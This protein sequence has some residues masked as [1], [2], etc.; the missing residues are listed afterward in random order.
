VARDAGRRLGRRVIGVRV[1]P[2]LAQNG[3]VH[4]H[5]GHRDQGGG[6]DSRRRTAFTTRWQPACPDTGAGAGAGAGAEAGAGDGYAPANGGKQS[7]SPWGNSPRNDAEPSP[8]PCA[9][10]LPPPFR[11]RRPKPSWTSGPRP[12]RVGGPCR[13]QLAANAVCGSAAPR[14]LRVSSLGPQQWVS[15]AVG[16][17]PTAVVG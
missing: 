7:K 4:T 3:G 9:A 16:Q 13:L 5:R 17:E 6:R 14:L 12:S 2:G 10:A 8:A 15:A 11:S 1:V